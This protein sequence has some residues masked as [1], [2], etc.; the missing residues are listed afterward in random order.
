MVK[1]FIFMMLFPLWLMA[2]PNV[3]VQAELN[4]YSIAPNKPL[5]GTLMITHPESVEIDL[6]SATMEGKPLELGLVQKVPLGDDLFINIY[7][8]TLP[9]YK[10]G[11]YNLPVITIKVGD[12]EYET[13]PVR[14]IVPDA[15]EVELIESGEP[16]YLGLE[17]EVIKP[18]EKIYPGQ[19]LSLV[20][21]YVYR[22]E[23]QLDKEQLPLL[24]PE[25]FTKIG[26][27]RVKDY[28]RNGDSIR[29]VTLEVQA[30]E[31]GEY[32]FAESRIEGTG[33]HSGAAPEKLLATAP[34]LTI[35]VYPFPHAQQPGSFEGAYGTF[36]VE[37]A[38]LSSDQV[39]VGD[40]LL[41]AVDIYGS[42]QSLR[43]VRLPN[44][45]CQPGFSG[46]FSFDSVPVSG[47][48]EGDKKR[49]IIPI[50]PTNDQV[51]Q[52]PAVYFS[53][54]D[55]AVKEYKTVQSNAIDIKVY[56]VENV[57]ISDVS[58]KPIGETEENWKAELAQME[59][60][61]ENDITLLGPKDLK[62]LGAGTWAVL[63][64]L[65]LGLFAMVGQ[66]EWKKRLD[67]RKLQPKE[68]LP[69]DLFK[70]AMASQGEEDLFFWLL[71]RAMIAKLKQQGKISETITA[72]EDLPSGPIKEFLIE[73]DKKRFG[74][75]IHLSPQDVSERA[76]EL[77]HRSDA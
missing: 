72:I 51:T 4:T 41:L 13:L 56:P 28:A 57:A 16:P 37:T 5:S 73:I 19:R 21:R 60:L 39:Y 70:Q 64:I 38:L 20:Y 75:G 71:S 17:V 74:E 68:V 35:T 48:L 14:F 36:E 67:E 69:E 45:K 76:R 18:S 7:Q 23:V 54:Y 31:P 33:Y 59:P 66:Y 65:P 42:E 30:Q 6:T 52:I 47:V 62:N 53:F 49:F 12:R 10:P 24:N 15:S 2:L 1:T 9:P 43:N 44:L 58:L 8:F 61:T 3:N 25:G 50:R 29:E 46:L 63:W 34:A 32:Q 40:K 22:G 77:F 55:P 26:E 27:E 11:E